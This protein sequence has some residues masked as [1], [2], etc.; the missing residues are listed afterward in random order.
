MGDYMI[1]VILGIVEG[2][3]EY[4]PISSTG[5]MIL[6][7]D[8]LGFTGP[9]ASVFEVFIQLGAILSVLVIYKEKFIR[10]L[11]QYRCWDM[12]RP[13]NWR[14]NDTG[15]TLAHVGAGIVPVMIIGYFAHGVIKTYL[16]SVGTVII[17]LVIG[18]VFMLLAERA[19]IRVLCD[20]VEKMTI[21]QA[22]LV[23]AF[24]MFALW[25]GFS[26]SGSTIAGGLFLGLSRKAA[27]DFSFIIAVPVMII[28]CFYDLLKSWS[29]LD[30]GDLVMIAI[31]FVTAFIVAYISVLWFLKFLNKSTL[32]SFACYRFL[33]AVVS[34]V[35]FF[36]L[37]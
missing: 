28:A 9:R 14:R 35:Y 32:T 18:G 19:K 2:V 17:G 6:V 16:F 7:G 21:L 3:T 37:K 23:G 25:P 26:R 20:D 8:W 5:H 34:F 29:V 10:M 31:G 1:A 12:L 33:V 30:S 11:R 15:L 22:F 36:I 27:A 24:Q 13:Q 4:L